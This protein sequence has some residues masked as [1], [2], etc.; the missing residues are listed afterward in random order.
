MKSYIYVVFLTCLTFVRATGQETET[1]IPNFFVSAV[2]T[3][4]HR[5]FVPSQCTAYAMINCSDLVKDEELIL[6]RL[7]R[8][9]LQRQLSDLASSEAAEIKLVLR[10]TLSDAA[11]VTRNQKATI[12]DTVNE[13]CLA[14]GFTNVRTTEM[15]TS[16]K[17]Y[18]D[19]SEVLT[20]EEVEDPKESISTNQWVKAFPL[21][22]RLSKLV[23]GSFDCVVEIKRPFDGRELHLTKE[24]KQAIADAVDSTELGD[25]RETLLF[26]ISSTTAGVPVMEKLFDSRE[27]VKI[28]PDASGPILD[29][30]VKRRAEYKPSEARVLAVDLGFET[31]RYT[32]SPNGGAPEKLIGKQAPDFKLEKLRGEDEPLR[33]F[34]KERPAL[35]TFWGVACGP[36]CL[37]AP[38]LTE[39]HEKYGDRIT[40]VAVNAYNE[41]PQKVSAFVDRE[42][43]TH[44]IA[45]NGRKIAN[46]RYHVGAY[47]TTFWIDAQGIVQD[48]VVG[49][50]SAESLERQV[51]RML[52]EN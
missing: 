28:P 31:I 11:P 6:K 40:I 7:D 26:K 41:S 27:P 9:T 10:Y 32:H 45:L 24:L 23:L 38:H 36:C 5:T 51:R 47:P 37:E 29:F 33:A 13:I 46:D 17:W 8:E 21:R 1:E 44:P 39:M 22:T 3:E 16:A 25:Q 35:V 49:F 20:Y 18:D 42:Q 19:L 4:L 52:G 50:D 30:L 34:I 14:A 48:Y 15:S 2:Q 12:R 43:L